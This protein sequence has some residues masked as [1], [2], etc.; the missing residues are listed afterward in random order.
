ML[1]GIARA[2]FSAP[3]VFILTIAAGGATAAKAEDLVMPYSCSIQGRDLHVA[4]ANETSYR[5]IGRRDEQPFA[6]CTRGGTACETMMV[7]R[8]VI[9]CD[10]A[11]V[12]WSRVTQAATSTGAKLPAGLPI[13]YAPVSTM[14]GRFVL[15]ALVRTATHISHVSTQDLSPDSVIE[16]PETAHAYAESDPQ[17][18]TEVR[19][20]VLLA[21][22]GS[23]A[24][25]VAA[26]IA[27]LMLTLFGASMLA[28]GRWRLP[29]L[30]AASWASLPGSAGAMANRARM[31]AREALDQVREA[32]DE[33][34]TGSAA[35]ARTDEA[36]TALL[37]LNARLIEIEFAVGGLP[38]QLLLRD[39]LS[40]EIVVIRGRVADLERQSKRRAPD[41]TVAITRNILRDLDRISR[42][43][44]SAAQTAPDQSETYAPADT[45]DEPQ[46]MAD[47]YRVLGINPDAAPAVAKKLVDA[48]RMSWHPDHA[49]DEGDRRTRE[50][51]MKQINAAW[52]LV[53]GHQRAAA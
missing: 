26:T 3:V 21:V 1:R 27:G 2:V 30:Q 14:S 36:D 25:H 48:L 45:H 49:R 46:T 40:S 38:P 51:R 16:R 47:A 7:H 15:P 43:A 37:M 39:V 42:I 22:P 6:A 24:G 17:W 9:D 32:L 33:R 23:T 20:D 52:D 11:Q 35:D 4:P 34:W 12:P 19:S 29:S 31:W 53:K 5:I 50:S 18:V 13:G 41:K 28:A 8:F 44:N 10:G